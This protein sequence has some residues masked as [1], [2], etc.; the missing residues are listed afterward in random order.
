MDF[1]KAVIAMTGDTEPGWRNEYHRWYDQEHL[2]ER[3]AVKGF[4]GARRYVNI[5]GQGPRELTLYELESA[6]VLEKPEYKRLFNPPSDWSQRISQHIKLQRGVFKNVFSLQ[7]HKQTNGTI[8]SVVWGNV[9]EGWDDDFN[10]WYNEEHIQE[11]IEAGYLSARRF[12]AIVGD[13]KYLAVYEL[14]DEKIIES[15]AY[16]NMMANPSEFTR[17]LQGHMTLRHIFYRQEFSIMG[18][19]APDG[20][21][22]EPLI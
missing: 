8:L 22:R 14:P 12:E 15:S 13:W 17:K 1:G 19:W 16:K 7:G 21:L 18:S 6:E 20:S 2:V 9:E 5:K 10:R 11:R 4:L 3:M